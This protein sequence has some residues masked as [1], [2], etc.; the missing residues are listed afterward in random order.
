MEP[1]EPYASLVRYNSWMNRTVYD[2]CESLS[3]AERKH[4]RGAFFGSI[5]RTLNHILLV[6]LLWLDRFQSRP[7]RF[8][9]LGEEIHARWDTLRA[10]RVAADAGLE[11][12]VAGVPEGDFAGTFTYLDTEGMTL[13]NPLWR[14]ATQLFNHQ[15]HHRGQVTTL[16]S[17]RGVDVGVTDF[18]RL[19]ERA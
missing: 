2:A 18:I 14:I 13:T 15:T 4:E 9:D 19:P 17:Q 5:H 7:M 12:W 6:D 1:N 16:L 8:T 10:E 11:A 3:D